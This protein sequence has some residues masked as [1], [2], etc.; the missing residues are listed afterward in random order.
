MNRS[1][2]S[3][4]VAA[5][6]LLA[7]CGPKPAEKQD[8]SALATDE[9]KISYIMGVNVGSQMKADDF[10]LDTS[11]FIGGVED[12]MAGK[13]P[14]LSDEEA[15]TIVKSY[16]EKQ[17]AQKEAEHKLTAEKNLKEGQQYLAENAKKE[18]V[19]VL[20]SGMQYRV[21]TAGTGA[22]PKADD[23]VEVH[24]KG[25]LLD[26]TEFD[27]SYSRNQTETVGVS[28]VIPGWV[29]ALQLMKEGDKW[30]L[31]IPPDLAYGPGGSGAAIGPNQVLLFD[32]EL[33]KV[34]DKNAAEQPAA[35]ASAPEQPAAEPAPAE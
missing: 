11:A 14:R 32:V 10:K 8:A 17:Q 7:A 6:I 4:A 27:S 29:E 16:Q 22:T 12:I 18:G 20:A 23:T 2:T 1:L 34:V 21:V 26:G 15:M 3:L 19:K 5:G 28:Q 24:Y 25:T 35:E 13:E 9:Q 31:A 30:A 33:V